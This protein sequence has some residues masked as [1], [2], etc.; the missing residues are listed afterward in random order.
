MNFFQVNPYAVS[1][2]TVVDDDGWSDYHAM[3]LQLRRRY[4]NWLTANVNYTLA[5]NN[6]NVFTDNATQSANWITLRD[7]TRND[8]PAPFDV[9]HVLQTYGT[10]DLPVGRDRHY[11]ITNDVLNALAGG[12]T[13]GALFTVQV[14]DAIPVDQRPADRQWIRRRRGADER[15]HGRGHPEVA[16]S[17]F[18]SDAQFAVLGG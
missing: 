16:P 7:R 2:L 12:W 6:G 8:G 15:S 3:Q 4:A 17:P 10:Y 11:N 9:R 14:R 13:F 5:R 18:A 1:G